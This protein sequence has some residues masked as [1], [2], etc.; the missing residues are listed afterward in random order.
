MTGSLLHVR[1][2]ASLAPLSSRHQ[3]SMTFGDNRSRLDKLQGGCQPSGSATSTRYRPEVQ[4]IRGTARPAIRWGRRF[5]ATRVY[6]GNRESFEISLRAGCLFHAPRRG[7]GMATRA[8]LI[9]RATAAADAPARRPWIRCRRRLPGYV[10]QVGPQHPPCVSGFM[11]RTKALMN[12]PSTDS[13]RPG[14][15]RP[16]S[17]RKALASAAL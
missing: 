13:T 11:A 3:R 1:A 10:Q 8:P 17:A 15:S 9:R 12:R 4:E 7:D 2:R 5:Q 14:R 6:P 16:A